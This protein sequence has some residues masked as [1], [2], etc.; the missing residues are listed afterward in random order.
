MRKSL[1]AASGLDG[2]LS[3]IVI[4][5]IVSEALAKPGQLTICYIPPD[6]RG[7]AKNLTV[8]EEVALQHLAAHQDAF[9]GTCGGTEN[10][11]KMS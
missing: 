4:A 5:G 7:Q 9:L 1:V 8:A 11:R 3:V 2:L 10:L 6:G